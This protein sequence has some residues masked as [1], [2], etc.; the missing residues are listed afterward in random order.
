M[1]IC[2]RYP[3]FL[4]IVLYAVIFYVRNW[5]SNNVIIFGNGGKDKLFWHKF[6]GYQ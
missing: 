1:C 4:K 2:C 3:A 5:K 6:E